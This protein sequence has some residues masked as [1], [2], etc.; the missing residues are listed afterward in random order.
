MIGTHPGR[1]VLLALLLVAG[2][3]HAQGTGG[4]AEPAPVPGPASPPTGHV[5][6][7]IVA[8]AHDSFRRAYDSG[9][10]NGVADA[11]RACYANAGTSQPRVIQCLLE[12]ISAKR[13]DNAMRQVALE[14]N[15]ADPGPINAWLGDDTFN[16][17]VTQYAQPIFGTPQRMVDYFGTTTQQVVAR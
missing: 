17:R 15:H 3:A 6:P 2:A 7:A 5:P 8:A 13:L 14:R 1:N 9:R 16:T 10:M 12:D 4:S 11:I